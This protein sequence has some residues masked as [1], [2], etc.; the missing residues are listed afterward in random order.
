MNV[1]LTKSNST[2]QQ[3][4]AQALQQ[5]QR[6]STRNTPITVNRAR[7]RRRR[8]NQ[9]QRVN[10][11]VNSVNAMNLNQQTQ[12]VPK[13]RIAI[14]GNNQSSVLQAY[15]ECRLRPFSTRGMM[16]GIPDG[17]N[18]RR[19]LIDHRLTATATF[20][21]TGV[22][23]FIIAPVIPS[24]L[25]FWMADS[26]MTVNGVAATFNIGNP[27][28]VYPVCLLEWAGQAVNAP[29]ANVPGLISPLYSAAKFR[30]VTCGWSIGY[31]GTSL[32]NSGMMV[33]NSVPF[34]VDE[35][36]V[37]VVNYNVYSSNN[38]A[39]NTYTPG[40]AYYSALN[41]SALLS[42]NSIYSS[43][44]AVKVPLRCGAHGLL[45][46]SAPDYQVQKIHQEA[47]YVS[48][49]GDTVESFLTQQQPSP[50]TCNGSALVQG[51]DSGWDATTVRISGGTTG[52]SVMIDMMLC[53]EYFPEPSSSVFSIAKQGP[54]KAEGLMQ[55][56][57]NLAK[58]M[59]LASIGSA[60]TT[61]IEAASVLL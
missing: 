60:I 9:N 21:S 20:G 59:P 10:Q 43:S 7:R 22:I 58:D 49:P 40:Q 44:E 53:I 61:A 56:V 3:R 39:G 23:S 26:T 32:T 5:L 34:T 12:L 18:A 8:T 25:L 47:H 45:R 46:H 4:R 6:K 38:A 1:Q 15:K 16:T 28:M 52:Q 27:A 17:S 57:E 30:V 35:P 41:A 11:L 36:V 54:P 48:Q 2:K 50:T 24:P 19:I 51:I 14:R 42:N 13:R 55:Q 31:I 29:G 33:I 37:N